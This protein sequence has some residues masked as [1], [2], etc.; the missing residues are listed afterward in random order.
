[1]VAGA[2]PGPAPGLGDPPGLR[3][4]EIPIAIQDRSFNSDGGLFYP[5]SR[6]FFEGLTQPPTEPYLDIPFS[7]DTACSG[8][9]DVSPIW[10]P[11]F[12]GNTI[13]VNGKTWPFLE[14]E[15]RRYRFSKPERL[16][17]A[18]PH[19]QAQQR[20]APL[21]DRQR[22]RLPARPVQLE[23]FPMGPRSGPM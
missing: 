13:V 2:L 7:P 15:Q 9:S 11:E 4:Y 18:I 19:P 8:P 3:Y 23:Q 20:P 5:D 12:F 17:L 16:Q 10:N 6:A 22:G 1:M 21:A 14:V